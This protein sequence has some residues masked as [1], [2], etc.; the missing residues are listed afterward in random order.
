MPRHKGYIAASF[1][2]TKRNGTF[3]RSGMSLKLKGGGSSFVVKNSSDY[4]KIIRENL[5]I[6][7]Q[8]LNDNT[9][10]WQGLV[11]AIDVIKTNAA[12]E[13]ARITQRQVMEFADQQY[14][15][16]FEN[17]QRGVLTGNTKLSVM[18]AVYVKTRLRI[19]GLPSVEGRQATAPKLNTSNFKK[20]VRKKYNQ[21]GEGFIRVKSFRTG[22]F[23]SFPIERIQNTSG[24]Y[25][26]AEA[27]QYL[28]SHR[29]GRD[30]ETNKMVSGFALTCGDPKEPKYVEGLDVF[31]NIVSNY[32]YDL[33]EKTFEDV[34]K[35]EIRAYR[36]S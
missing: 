10:V 13:A 15:S 7:G 27:Y 3:G 2:M 18:S 19:M 30:V 25:A 23:V 28:V 29:L 11:N 31:F 32:A 5:I 16:L 4:K 6:K 22:K 20:Y 35:R 36:H 24:G 17:R 8:T 1:K 9:V 33:F 34:L 14:K 12:D 21:N 26:R